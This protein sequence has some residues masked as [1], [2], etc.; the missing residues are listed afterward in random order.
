[1]GSIVGIT[2]IEF[3]RVHG[4]KETSREICTHFGIT[5]RQLHVLRARY[6]LPVKRR[7][8]PYP[9]RNKTADPTAAEIEERAAECRAKRTLAE[10]ARMA[11]AGRVR[12]EMP[13]YSFNGRD[14]AFSAVS[15]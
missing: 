2:A 10:K 1:M 3:F 11:R 7:Q 12:W 13:V 14:A 6:G 15:P 4:E 9:S 8:T 5:S